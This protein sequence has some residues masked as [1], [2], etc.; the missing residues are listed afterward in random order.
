[1]SLL[2]YP[3]LPGTIRVTNICLSWPLKGSEE[4]NLGSQAKSKTGWY[5]FLL[6]AAVYWLTLP[7]LILFIADKVDLMLSTRPLAVGISLQ[8]DQFC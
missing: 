2:C 6:S 5:R 7:C 8:L 3:V 4:G 1:M